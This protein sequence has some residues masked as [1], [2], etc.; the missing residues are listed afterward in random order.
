MVPRTW[1]PGSPNPSVQGPAASV[2]EGA[3]GSRR[4]GLCVAVGNPVGNVA[5]LI[6]AVRE[7]LRGSL[8]GERAGP[9][10]RGSITLSPRSGRR[11]EEGGVG[12]EDR[13]SPRGTLAF[14]S[15][16]LW[17]SRRGFAKGRWVRSLVGIR[18]GDFRSVLTPWW[19]FVEGCATRRPRAWSRGGPVGPSLGWD[20][21]RRF[22]AS[23]G[24]L[25]DVRRMVGGPSTSGW[26][27]TLTWAARV[28]SAKMAGAQAVPH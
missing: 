6:A 21:G 25:V 8:C 10:L 2:D 20:P 16:R 5:P 27:L 9:Q 1:G 4:W 15:W 11:V 14:V 26:P 23:C 22:A 3:G 24:P 19:T 28:L 13:T 17:E 12:Q 18:G 7:P